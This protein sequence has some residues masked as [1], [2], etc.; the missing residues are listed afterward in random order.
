[1]KV[2][3]KAVRD[4]SKN[5]GFPEELIE[6]HLDELINFTFAV[7]KRERKQCRK[8]IKK[9]IHSTDIIKPDLLTFLSEELENEDELYD[10]L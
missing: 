7:A 3:A 5:S 10:I 1:M 4:L 9:W 6:R 2:T 8:L